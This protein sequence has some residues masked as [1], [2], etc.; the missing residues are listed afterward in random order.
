MLDTKKHFTSMLVRV[1]DIFFLHLD[2]IPR[3]MLY[4][5]RLSTTNYKN[6]KV[7]LTNGTLGTVG[8]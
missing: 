2:S 4:Y 5:H 3:I 1:Y 7:Q 8:Y 6:G